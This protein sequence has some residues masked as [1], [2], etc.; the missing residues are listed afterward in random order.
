[1]VLQEL[2][3]NMRKHSMAGNV[4]LQFERLEERIHIYY[5]DN[6]VGMSDDIIFNNGLTNTGNRIAAIDGE[7]TF[8]TQAE[9]GLKIHIHFPIAKSNI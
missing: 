1:V 7:I 3:V 9:Q 4:V 8:E 2:M 5:Q 6:G